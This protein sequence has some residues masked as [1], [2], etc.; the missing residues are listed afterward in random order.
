[1]ALAKSHFPLGECPDPALAQRLLDL[2]WEAFAEAPRD[3]NTTFLLGC[4]YMQV[5]K[6]RR[7]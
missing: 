6:R 5:R 3:L 4:H 1:V 7:R 2:L